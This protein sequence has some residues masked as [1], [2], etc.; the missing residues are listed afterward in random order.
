MRTKTFRVLEAFQMTCCG[1]QW[2][3]LLAAEDGE[4]WEVERMT[5]DPFQPGWDE[6][7][8]IEV[9]VRR[10]ES[11]DGGAVVIPIWTTVGVME[12]RQMD[13]QK[14]DR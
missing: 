10:T 12:S 4:T 1:R 5:I 7:D 11:V 13:R 6:G 14:W 2:R 8:E 3:Y 9:E